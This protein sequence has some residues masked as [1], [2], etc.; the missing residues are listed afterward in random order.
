MRQVSLQQVFENKKTVQTLRWVL[1]AAVLAAVVW[2][3]FIQGGGKRTEPLEIACGRDAAGMLL[4][5]LQQNETSIDIIDFE[6]VEV[7]DC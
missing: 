6:Y 5:Y 1:T 3:L 2:A 4:A 7:G